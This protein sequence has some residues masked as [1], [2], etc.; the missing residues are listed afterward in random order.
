M[1]LQKHIYP[2][3]YALVDYATA[4]LAWCS[5]YFVRKLI[6]HE[7]FDIDTH[8]WIGVI[9]IPAC[10][11]LLY[12]LVGSYHSIYKKSRLTEF[13]K[14][15]FCSLAGCL[16][17]Y[18]LLL[19]NDAT[20][21]YNYYY[22]GFGAL[23]LIHFVITWA[24]RFVVLNIV[25]H[26]LQQKIV[27]FSAM[28]VGTQEDTAAIYNEA[29][30]KLAIEG[31][32]VEGYVPIAS[33]NSSTIVLPVLGGL[34]ELETIIDQ[35]HIQLVIIAID[36][37]EQALIGTI[38]NR[39]SDKDVEIRIQPSML[40]I[41]AGSVRTSNV[42][43]TVLIELNTTLMPDWQQHI[44]R[45]IDVVVALTGLVLLSPL[46]L[47]IA[48]R[49]RLSSPGPVI[50]KQ[51]RVGYKNRLF[52]MYKFRS[53]YMGAEKNGPSLSSDNDA[54]ITV[55]GRTMRKWRLDE[56]PQL[57]NVL[58]GKMSL[59]GPRPERQFYID[60]IVVRFPYY[61]HLL[62][63]KPGITSWGMVQYG[64]AENVEAMI[65]R[66]RFDLVY[67]ENV[68]L[69]LDFKILLHTLRIIFSGKGK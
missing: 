46:L 24:G 32:S 23:L 11:L 16:V 7:S 31:Y 57:W 38:I 35:Q 41:L 10:W 61:K 12:A 39:L 27:S 37:T 40:D 63:V 53:M 21:D 51:E 36:K 49:V 55:W 67:I 54:R 52:C 45:V 13:I 25:K 60:Q 3:W 19:L 62:K 48:I 2:G 29:K 42:L 56:L 69:L 33:A 20:N 6:L 68:S 17:L 30:D 9:F 64:Y 34:D 1:P 15:L 44:K 58:L 47:Y 4:A 66:S 14:T 28:I 18:F 8:F 26:Q 65:E 59:V 5:F 22:R 50:F 43:G